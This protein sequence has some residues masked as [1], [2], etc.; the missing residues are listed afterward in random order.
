M[1]YWYGTDGKRLF[2]VVAPNWEEARALIDAYL[3]GEG[4][5]GQTAGF[6][7]VRSELPGRGQLPHAL[8][9]PGP[10]PDDAPTCSRRSL[11]NA[12]P[13]GARGH[14]QGAGLP[15]C[16]ASTP[17]ASE[18]YEFHLVDPEPGGDRHRQGRGADLPGHWPAPNQ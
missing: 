18:G 4:G 15:G 12:R 11:K 9:H 1:N 5:V 2:Q 14:A 17:Q 7:A 16:L 6:K 3:K 13:E 10:G 8:Q